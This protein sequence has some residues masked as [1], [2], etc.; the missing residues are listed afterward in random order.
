MTETTPAAEPRAEVY[1]ARLGVANTPMSSTSRVD[2]YESLARLEDDILAAQLDVLLSE[3]NVE[4][5]TR[6]R[7]RLWRD[8]LKGDEYP[9]I[10]Q[11]IAVER[12]DD[13][14]WVPLNIEFTAPQVKVTESAR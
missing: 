13:G 2:Y 8:F 10:T 9:R 12:F 11:V 3:R 14:R 7:L 4:A 5:N 1:R 6:R